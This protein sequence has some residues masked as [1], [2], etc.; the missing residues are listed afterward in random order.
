MRVRLLIYQTMLYRELLFDELTERRD[1]FVDFAATQAG[2]IDE[3]LTVLT[4]LAGNPSA[5]R[6]ILAADSPGSIPSDELLAN[7]GFRVPFEHSW[8]NH[9]ESRKWALEVLNNRT[10]FAADGSQIYVQKETSL[11]VGAVQIGWFENP[12]SGNKDYEKRASFELLSPKALLEN[13]EEPLN[14]ETRVGE[15]RFH[16]EVERAKA[17]I[18]K[19]RGWRE[20][21]ERMPLAFFD[22]TLLVSFSLPQTKL[23]Q[24]FLDVMLDLVNFS[25]D[26]VVPIVGYI[27]RSFARDFIALVEY[28]KPEFDSTT[29]YDVPLISTSTKS[30]GRLLNRWGE[31]TSF[32]YAKRKGLEMFAGAENEMPL[33]GFS[34][35]QTSGDAGPARLDVPSW[36]YEE[37]FLDEVFDVIR[38]ECVIGLGY[39]YPLE[40]ADATALISNRDREVFI[41]ALREFSDREGLDFSVSRKNA[42]K[43]RR[44]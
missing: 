31:R 23:Q 5:I 35:L 2:E 41:A 40:T 20:K 30:E 13:Q 33:V 16:A 24:S 27:D 1:D 15:R 25:K 19:H 34:Y 11:P 44:R 18:D 37:G 42:S 29:L 9:E 12:H 32:C 10:T 8:S 7:N 6:S 22:G 36:I 17:F 43:A 38:A 39:P 28:L 4:S 14:P 26:C 3:Y 21:G